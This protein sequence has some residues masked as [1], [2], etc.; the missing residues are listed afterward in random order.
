MAVADRVNTTARDRPGIIT[1]VLSVVGYVLVGGALTGTLPIFPPLS[2]STVALFSH[3][4]AVVNT[5]ALGSILAGVYFI[6]NDEIRKHRAAMLTAFGLIVVFLVLYL[7]KTGGGFEKA[8][9]A[10]GLPRVAYLVMLGIHIFLS[11]VSVPV[12]LYAV[13][14]GLTHS[15]EELPGTR[16]KQVGRVA[17]TAWSVSLFLGIV[18]YLLLNHVYGWEPLHAAALLLLAGPRFRR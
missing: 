1:A 3:L 13:I 2:D 8:I 15:P 10:T 14:L 12:V 9:L 6:R 5:L 17:A 7:W 4:I 18:T 16:H 11:V